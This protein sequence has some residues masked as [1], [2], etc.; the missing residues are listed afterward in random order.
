M[1]EWIERHLKTWEGVLGSIIFFA[2]CFAALWKFA[3]PRFR[4][5]YSRTLAIMNLEETLAHRDTEL[6]GILTLI[7]TRLDHLDSGQ[8]NIIQGRRGIMEED[9]QKAWFECDEH[10]RFTWAN[11]LWRSFTG[12]ESDHVRGHGWESG[13]ANDDREELLR[14]WRDAYDHQ[15]IFESRTTLVNRMTGKLTEVRLS[16]W[17]IRNEK[18]GSIISYLGHA[19]REVRKA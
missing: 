11:R 13:I 4:R 9:E 16:S 12:M 14:L 2:G 10:G 6:K 18:T 15:R 7:Y 1:I 19:T 8:Q 5:G 17:P 3:I